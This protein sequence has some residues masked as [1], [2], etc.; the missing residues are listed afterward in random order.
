MLKLLTAWLL[1]FSV[2]TV[3][4]SRLFVYAGFK[5]NQSYIAISLSCIATVNV[6]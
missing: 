6:T 1:I 3:N 2:L 5:F 4:F